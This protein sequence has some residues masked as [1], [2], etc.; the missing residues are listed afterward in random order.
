MYK[1]TIAFIRRDDEL[2]LLNR[3]N[4]PTMGLW[5]GVGGKMEAGETPIACI[6]REVYEET[7]IRISP[8]QV[9][10]QSVVSWTINEE[11]EGGMH[12]YVIE[13]P[14]DFSYPTPIGMDEGI[15][16]WKKS[17]WVFDEQNKGVGEMIP[18]YLPRF[19]HDT[20]EIDYW[21]SINNG[22]VVDYQW[23]ELN[24]SLL[25]V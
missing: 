23:K 6:I 10:H 18:L 1:Q 12:A 4:A 5:N 16:D 19:L 15:L 14:A 20:E 3:N 11:A 22:R 25:K 24:G 21:F 13:V 7:G 2:L 9:V 17:S 8:E